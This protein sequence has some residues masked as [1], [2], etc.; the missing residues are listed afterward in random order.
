[1][2]FN[3]LTKYILIYVSVAIIGFVGVTVIS[4]K[5]DYNRVYS[6]QTENMY[7][8]AVS[9]AAEF[10]PDYFSNDK[11]KLIQLELHT[12]TEL[13]HSRIMFVDMD[14]N[15]ILDT[16]YNNMNEEV[17]E[18]GILY[19][20]NNFDVS[21]LGTNHSMNGNFYG[22]FTEKNVSVFAPITN[23]FVMKG[24]VVVHMPESV[25]TD[26]VY[27]TFNTN[28]ITLL[29]IL[30]LNSAFII[31]YIIHIHNPLKDI[32]NA[33]KEYGRGN[34]SYKVAVGHNDE[35]GQLSAS[36]NYMATQ[37]N[38][39]DQFQQK[40]LSNISHDFRSPLTSIKGYLEAIADG[41][42]PPEMINK[43]INIVL[44]ETDRLTKL[45]SNILTLNELDPKSVRLDIS[46]FDINA[47]IKH[48]IE[49]FEG[50]CKK[51]K[52]QFQL[53]F[54]AEKETGQC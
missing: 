7:R 26:R 28:Y 2:K 54:S 34:L 39:M 30:V 21:K 22:V 41:T 25:I 14:G 5:I 4:Y 51:K 32:T 19:T 18:N 10:A 35:I 11:L 52:I 46:S 20:I 31:L 8:Q 13:D 1:M 50:T 17:D 29:I 38:E 6:E 3:L 24:Y 37:I 23:K 47:L 45:T 53:T 27:T 16:Q 36:L 43:Y 9:I 49:T 44:F 12:I 42:I 40:F 15:V 33:I 48:T